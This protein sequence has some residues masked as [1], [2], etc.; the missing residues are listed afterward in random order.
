MQ[1]LTTCDLYLL[2]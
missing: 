1:S 2:G